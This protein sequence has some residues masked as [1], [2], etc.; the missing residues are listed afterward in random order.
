MIQ[1]WTIADDE[2]ELYVRGRTVVCSSGSVLSRCYT[3][4]STVT[5]VRASEKSV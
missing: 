5:Q 1:W 2:C 4:E 3:V